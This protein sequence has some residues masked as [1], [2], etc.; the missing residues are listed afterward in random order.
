LYLKW[1]L[2]S[3]RLHKEKKNTMS[4]DEDSRLD[5]E[6]GVKRR[7]TKFDVLPPCAADQNEMMIDEDGSFEEIDERQIKWFS[8][9]ASVYMYADNVPYI[10]AEHPAFKLRIMKALQKNFTYIEK[11][12]IS[13]A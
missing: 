6:R 8:T 1:K 12:Q 3:S 9:P 7:R 13:I 4:G 11:Y 10:P 5:T 2:K